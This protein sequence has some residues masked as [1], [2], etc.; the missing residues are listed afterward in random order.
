MAQQL[1]PRVKRFQQIKKAKR[2]QAIA[3]KEVPA[4]PNKSVAL[5]VYKWREAQKKR[6]KLKI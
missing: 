3:I 1:D 6:G 5:N 2:E 4:A